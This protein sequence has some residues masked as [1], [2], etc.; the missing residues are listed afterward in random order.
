VA[1]HPSA[2]K[3]MRQNLRRRTRNTGIRSSVK[4]S[5]KKVLHAVEDHKVEEAQEAL[6]QVTS[7]LHKSTSKG[8]YH[9]NTTSRKISRLARKVN[10]LSQ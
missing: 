5:I 9:T 6:R 7:I 10:A 4:T 3:R 8:V 1:N 2:L